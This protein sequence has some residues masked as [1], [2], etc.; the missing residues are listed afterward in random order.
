MV[1]LFTVL[2]QQVTAQRTL[3]AVPL[4]GDAFEGADQEGRHGA[5]EAEHEDAAPQLV[6]ELDRAG[7][8]RL[9]G[10]T[11]T[12]RAA[13]EELAEHRADEG[14]ADGDPRRGEQERQRRRDAESPEHHAPA[15]IDRP[16]EL[17]QVRVDR[18]EP[19]DRVDEERHEAHQR[20]D[21]E[22]RLE[23]EPEPHDDRRRVGDDRC[24]LD[25]HGQR[26]RRPFDERRMR[27]HGSGRQR[28]HERREEAERRLPH[29]DAPV[30]DVEARVTGDVLQDVP[31]R[32]EH[33]PRHVEHRDE[34]LPQE[35]ERD[36]PDQ[37]RTEAQERLLPGAAI[38]GRQQF[39]DVDAGHGHVGNP[40]G[41]LARIDVVPNAHERALVRA[42]MNDGP[43]GDRAGRGRARGT[44]ASPPSRGAGAVRARSARRPRSGRAALPS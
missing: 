23:P 6:E 19:R 8:R 38:V 3:R 21:D 10:V 14:E 15:G 1:E 27:H 41:R 13:G 9:H 12:G 31:R 35:Q 17:E 44:P 32:R 29:R 25:E 2:A 7:L 34:D 22:D 18:S 16:G 20:R 40:A 36:H 11:E 39:V 33:E 5:D 42:V 37:R 4:E 28:Q 26:H 24:H 30:A 43:G